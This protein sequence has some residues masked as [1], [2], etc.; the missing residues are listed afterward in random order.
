MD[1]RDGQIID[2][3][4]FKYPKECYE[5]EGR[6][7]Q[8]ELQYLGSVEA[9]NITYWSDGLR[10]SGF[11]VKP[12]A[13]GPHPCIIYNRGGN[14]DFASID[15]RIVT[16]LLCR[17]ASWGYVVVASQYRGHGINEGRDEFGGRDLDDVL[18]LFPLLDA[19][20]GADASRIG[21]YGG[22]R[23][24]MMTYLTLTRTARVRAAVV[25]CGV[26]DLTD[27]KEDRN[28]MEQVFRELIPGFDPADD[29]PLIARSAVRWADRLCKS[30]P[31]LMMQGTADWRVN[32]L[33]ALRFAEQLLAA[34]HPF[35]LVML[36]GSDH[37][38][39]EHVPE[40]DRLTREWFDRFVR[41]GSPL[42]DVR[43]HGD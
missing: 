22:S 31:L 1:S 13:G 39:T 11:L 41:N 28:D 7:L 9:S 38:L 23:G 15:A 29:T 21:M 5:Q 33:S 27:W 34:Q 16:Q 43:P 20:A 26:S 10:I 32:P 4:P 35:R 14:R 36:E 8:P 12:S 19:E 18:N 40:R 6:V 42:P 37:A 3:Q 30:T 17:M 25:R 24:G 2:R